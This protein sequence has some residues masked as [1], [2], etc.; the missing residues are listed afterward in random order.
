MSLTWWT[1]SEN[2][3]FKGTFFVPVPQSGWLTNDCS[4]V[5]GANKKCGTLIGAPEDSVFDGVARG[6]INGRNGE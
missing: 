1:D 2:I 4:R 3:N 6:T 5:V